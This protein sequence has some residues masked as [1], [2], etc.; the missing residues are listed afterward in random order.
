MVPLSH[1]LGR[2]Q[3]LQIKE[4]SVCYSETLFSF[5]QKT[6]SIVLSLSEDIVELLKVR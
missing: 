5:T 2:S 4:L 3:F 1:N 6:M